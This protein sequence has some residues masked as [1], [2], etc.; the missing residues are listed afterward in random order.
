MAWTH[1]L[2]FFIA[3]GLMDAGVPAALVYAPPSFQA[4]A[5]T[6]DAVRADAGHLFSTLHRENPYAEGARRALLDALAAADRKLAEPASDASPA[7]EIP[8]LGASSPALVEARELIDEVD[9]EILALLAR[10]ALLSRRAAAAKA[11][12]GVGVR[13][14]RR[15]ALLLDARRRDASRLGLDEAAVGE[16]FEA[17]LRFSRKVQGS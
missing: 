10:R 8:D 16:I 9:G 1:A 6:I 5:R 13:D 2:A 3:K 4:I 7:I 15:E 11:E 12:L 17:V 14:A